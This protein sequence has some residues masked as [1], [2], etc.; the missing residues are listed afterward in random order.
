MN[1]LSKLAFVAFIMFAIAPAY[2]VQFYNNESMVPSTS[3]ASHFQNNGDGTVSDKSTGL[4]WKQCSE[5]HSGALCLGPTAMH[6]WKTAIEVAHSAVFAGHSDWRLPN[7]NELRSI[8]EERCAHPAIN[9]VVF[10]NTASTYYW[11]SSPSALNEDESY[12][13][14]FNWGSAGSY[15]RTW[16]FRLRLVRN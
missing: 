1:K 7:I 3:P 5:G 2:S 10:P 16:L 8:V 9:L 4:M 14:N 15:S 11:S 6:D 12:D 13:V